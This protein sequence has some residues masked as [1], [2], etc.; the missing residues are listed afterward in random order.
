[1]TTYILRRLIVSI[2]V[3]VGLSILLFFFIHLLP[4]D[5]AETILG[6]HATPELAEAL[7]HR[8]GL[9]QSIPQQYLTYLGQLA[10]GDLGYS[11]VNNQPV[12][13][14]FLRRFPATIEL[15]VAALVLAGIGG[16]FAGRIAARFRNSPTDAGITVLTLIGVSLPVFVLGLLLQYVFGVVFQVLP[17]SGRIDSRLAVGIPMPTGF[18]LV[19]TLLAGRPDAFVDALRHLLLPAI[20]LGSIPLALIARITRAAAIDAGFQDYVRTARA[21]GLQERR[22]DSRH[23]MRNAWLPVVTIIGLQV[24]TLLGGAVITETIFAWNGVGKWVVEGIKGHDYFVVQNS[25]MIFAVVFVLV[26]LVVD[27][28]YAVLDPRIRYAS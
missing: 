24:G 10:R 27:V 3:L 18:M 17:A 22:I 1:M 15:T 23:V 8:L 9:D 12:L 26:N 7:R 6:V 4:G 19:D 16:V 21:K 25:I 28:L 14:E 5:P 13:T 20:A 2:P 11:F